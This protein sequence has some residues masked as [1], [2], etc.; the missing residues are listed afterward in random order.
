MRRKIQQG[1][2]LIELMIVV[3]IIGILAAVAI[4]A[5]MDYMKK[6]KRTEAPLQLRII[7]DKSN[8]YATPQPRYA[9]SS[10]AQFAGND[11]A[12]CSSTTGKM[13]II[14]SSS[15]FSDSAWNSL[16]FHIDEETQFTYHFNHISATQAAAIAVGDLDCD[17]TM[18]SY[19]M[20]MQTVEGNLANKLWTPDDLGQKD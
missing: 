8:D 17:G 7:K 18:I 15:W 4:P 2:T 20:D 6:S 1:F 19:S 9:P 13:A 10:V 12:A 5:F 3:A 16:D 11:G 14:P